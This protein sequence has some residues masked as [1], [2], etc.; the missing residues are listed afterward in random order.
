MGYALGNPLP[1]KHCPE[2]HIIPTLMGRKSALD[3]HPEF[4]RRRLLA[5]LSAGAGRFRG[6]FGWDPWFQREQEFLD[7]AF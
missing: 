4:V 5:D 6:E 7:A 3:V 1:Q 2:L